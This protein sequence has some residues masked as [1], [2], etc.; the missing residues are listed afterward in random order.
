MRTPLKRT[1][2]AVLAALIGAGTQA[3]RAQTP[4][5]PP[6]TTERPAGD[7]PPVM[8]S[9]FVVNSSSNV[10]Y[11]ALTSSSSSRLNEQ[12]IDIPQTVNVVTSEFMQDA[13]LLDSREALKYVSNVIP[14]TNN[15]NL[16]VFLIRG[17]RS[18][19]TYI[20]G[21][22]ASHGA[23]FDTS[24][25]DRVEVVKGPTSAAF[26]RGEPAGLINFI[27]KTPLRTNRDSVTL[28][29][30][31]DN[32]YR[33]ELDHNG[34]VRPGVPLYYRL[35]SFYHNSDSPRDTWH[36]NRAG[37]LLS[38][39]WDVTDKTSA[40]LQTSYQ[41]TTSPVSEGN[42]FFKYKPTTD[43]LRELGLDS[44][45]AQLPRNMEVNAEPEFDGAS[46][47]VD[48]IWVNLAVDSKLTDVF[49]THQNLR[50]DY[51]TTTERFWID[52]PYLTNDA[53]KYTTPVMWRE[54]DV[55]SRSWRYQGDFL[56]QYDVAGTR[57]RTLFGYELYN[58]TNNFLVG[59]DSAPIDPRTNAPYRQDIFNPNYAIPHT[60]ILTSDKYYQNVRSNT[61]GYGI[62]LQQ[63][64]SLFDDRLNLTVS[65]RTDHVDDKQT[66]RISG[67]KTE[68]NQ[69]T[70]VVPRYA[71]IYKPMKWLS[72]YG[73][74]SKH[75]DPP[76]IANLYV[77][78]PASDPRSRETVA[79]TP[80]SKLEEFGAKTNLW[81]G[82]ATIGA[83]YYKMKR[84][85]TLI[86]IPVF[87]NGLSFGKNSVSGEDLHGWE[88]EAFGR[89]TDRLTFY[90]GYN[91]IRGTEPFGSAG[92]KAPISQAPDT[93]TA[94][95]KFDLW[96]SGDRVFSIDAGTKTFIGGWRF[97]PASF[98]NYINDDQTV[99]DLGAAYSWS[100][101]RQTVSFRVNNID[102]KFVVMT[103]NS[104]V[105]L[106]Q[107][108]LSYRF[109]F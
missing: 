36:Y 43:L 90:I 18:N 1:A 5:T 27:T 61:D 94:H 96:K 31:S 67:V 44:L 100:G 37:F 57:Q 81:N 53:G 33:A 89:P 60:P 39:L 74:Y 73:L 40:T 47:G 80:Q 71:A 97:H 51:Y 13:Q 15:H 24:F 58:F 59:L 20:D 32:L 86:Y 22:L 23:Q 6:A 85:G 68:V 62:Y 87:E 109:T 4:A 101:G 17:L 92:A 7:E 77:N 56:A 9:P 29:T 82:R 83:A 50:A 103:A 64:A 66:E 102:N 79:V 106:R 99:V 45:I 70:G 55:R 25:Y 76:S 19:S 35:V 46:V 98:T 2:Y 10:G 30:G 69:K 107:A 75:D 104:Q 105:Q 65:L 108:F 78:L 72:L 52:L 14:E 41:K 95:G 84:Q 63:Q 16:G 26:G 49:S 38:L 93:F 42:T 88:L 12:Y 8:V 48:S 54:S 3:A 21:S 91:Q 11:G 34:V 28:T